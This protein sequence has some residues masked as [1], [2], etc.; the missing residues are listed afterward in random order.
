MIE[1]KHC[2]KVILTAIISIMFLP[3]SK[4]QEY[5]AL[6]YMDSVEFSLITCSPHEEIYSLYGHSALRVHDLHKGKQNDAVFNWGIFN[7]NKPFFVLRFVFGLTDYELGIVGFQ[8][9]CDYYRRWGSTVTEQV[10]NLTSEEKL[11]LSYALEKNYQ[12]ENRIYRYNYFYDNCSTRPRD[13][14]LRSI[15][16]EVRYE[17]EGQLSTTFR[18]LI[19]EKTRRHEW[20]TFG[21]D[22]LLG[23]K[24]D[25]KLSR[26]EQ[27]FLPDRL[28]Y[29]FD[30]AQIKG[31]DG[32]WR[33]LI[34][35]RNIPVKPGVQ[36]VERDF[37]V[38]PTFCALLL[39]LMTTALCA[40]EWKRRKTFKY[41]DA[42]LMLLYG[43]AGC[44]LT[45]MLF[46][47]HPTTSTNLQVLLVNPVHLFYLPAILRRR[48]TRYWLVLLAM[49]CLFYIGSI[50]QHYAEGMLILAL[51]LL[52]R[53]WIHWKNEK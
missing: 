46:S 51:C 23:V 29:D 47:Q 14:I 44:L 3:Q 12:P 34:K 48:K 25:L 52:L 18:E 50:F 32:S 20:A 45:V 39:L 17:A 15:K 9:F 37:P 38:S 24:A 5:D 41:W 2:L 22:M 11:D 33:P 40:W 6:A 7:F 36:V 19:R 42:A 53:I 13:I 16:G 31:A 35:N 4:A 43:L 27:E 8:A 49:V 1:S 10:L 30:H 26:Q 21:N 28:L